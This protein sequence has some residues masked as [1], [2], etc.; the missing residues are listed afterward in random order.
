MVV[1]LFDYRLMHQFCG[2]LV[3]DL[4][5]HVVSRIIDPSFRRQTIEQ[6]AVAFYQQQWDAFATKI[7]VAFIC[8]RNHS[9]IH[10]VLFFYNT[11]VGRIVRKDTDYF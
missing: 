1:G 2:F 5:Y 4:S 8:I 11:S 7:P 10:N 3:T 9:D 6:H